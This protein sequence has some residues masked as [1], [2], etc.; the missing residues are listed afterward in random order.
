[1]YHYAKEVVQLL[2]N[3]GA[4]VN[5]QGGFYGNA[6]QAA[7]CSGNKELIQLLLNQ[8]A[9]VDAQGGKDGNARNIG[10]GLIIHSVLFH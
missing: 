7:S 4:E 1:L 3:Q 6:L 8:G 10:G 9:D 2:L 5:A